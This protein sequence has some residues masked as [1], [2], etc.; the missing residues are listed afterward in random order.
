VVGVTE[1]PDLPLDAPLQGPPHPHRRSEVAAP[2]PRWTAPVYLVLAVLLVPWI[3]YLGVV[4]PDHATA[5][6]W[7]IA[8]VG[9]DVMEFIALATTAW[10]SYRRSTWVSI[11]AAGTATLLIV[12]A[13]FDITTAN[14]GWE[15]TQALVSAFGLELPLAALSLWIARHA[16]LID[17]AVTLW[18]VERSSRQ[19]ER[20]RLTGSTDVAATVDTPP[21]HSNTVAS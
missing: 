18:L 9:F 19:A 13:W 17:D 14:G 2:A 12:D 1:F 8:W 3:I 21:Q 15:L 7:D 11:W 10:L 5:G 20:L 16:R 4:L 6:H